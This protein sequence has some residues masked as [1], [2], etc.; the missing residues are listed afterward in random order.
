MFAAIRSSYSQ[1]V[2]ISTVQDISALVGCIKNL[3]ALYEVQLC[4]NY[5]IQP[6][7]LAQVTP[8]KKFQRSKL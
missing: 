7:N 5:Q 2:F 8:E 1:D 6:L 4:E 3:M